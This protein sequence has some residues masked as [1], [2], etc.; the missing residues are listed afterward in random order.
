MVIYPVT[1]FS[2]PSAP[3]CPRCSVGVC[4]PCPLSDR[5]RPSLLSYLY[6]V[7]VGFASVLSDLIFRLPPFAVSVSVS[8]R[9]S[10]SGCSPTRLVVSTALCDLQD[11]GC[12]VASFPKVRKPCKSES[13]TAMTDPDCKLTA[14]LQFTRDWI[15]LRF[16]IP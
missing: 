3:T 13:L 5:A 2:S 14:L 10:V 16:C 15:K 11:K 6:L 7:S 9:S 1:Y 4:T 8:G 12:R